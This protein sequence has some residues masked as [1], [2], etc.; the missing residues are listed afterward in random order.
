MQKFKR[1]ALLIPEIFIWLTILNL[2]RACTIVES[3][4]MVHPDIQPGNIFLTEAC[5]ETEYPA[6]ANPVL[7]DFDIVTGTDEPV[8][9]AGTTGRRTWEQLP[10]AEADDTSTRRLHVQAIGLMAWGMWSQSTGGTQMEGREELPCTSNRPFPADDDCKMYSARLCKITRWCMKQ[11]WNARPT[12]ERRIEEA[13]KAI[14]C[15]ERSMYP[16]IRT[17]QEH[18][19]SVWMQL[20]LGADRW[21]IGGRTTRKRR[22]EEQ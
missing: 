7:G 20:D 16:S 10:E 18:E 3:A 5:G 22:G 1:R 12:L 2:A 19:L 21:P 14:G 9:G 13:E 11:D 15:L 4:D 6:D 17:M 8:Q